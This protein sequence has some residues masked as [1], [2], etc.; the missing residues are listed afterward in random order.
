MTNAAPPFTLA[1]M[2]AGAAAALTLIPSSAVYGMSFGIMAGTL[3]LTF[4]E[5]VLISGWVNAG[6]AQMASLQAWAYPVPILAVCL[7]TLAMNAR[8]LLMGATLRPWLGGLPAYVSYPSLLVLGDGNWALSMRERAE[9]RIDAGFLTG[10][11]IV[12]WINWVSSTALGALFG[13]V[14][15][16]PHRLGIDFMLA[17]F[18]TALAVSFYTRSRTV[19]PLAVGIVTAIVV[20]KLVAGPWYILAGALVGSVAGAL[21]AGHAR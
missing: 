17:A 20:E 14:I 3:G 1:G 12:M 6:G 7:M 10:S 11:G 5:I 21:R 19:L 13:Q 4:G 15:D 16:D 2:R 18:F 9:G 8:Y